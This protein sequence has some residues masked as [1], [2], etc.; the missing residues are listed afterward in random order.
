MS[1]EGFV[2][3]AKEKVETREMAVSEEMGVRIEGYCNEG[4]GGVS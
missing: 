4:D 3:Y 1:R 2:Y